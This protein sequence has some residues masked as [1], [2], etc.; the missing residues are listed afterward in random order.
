MARRG[1]RWAKRY[2]S[3]APGPS[4]YPIEFEHDPP[5]AARDGIV[6]IEGAL[7]L[8]PEALA[9]HYATHEAGHVVAAQVAGIPITSAR[10]GAGRLDASGMEVMGTVNY[11]AYDTTWVGFGA[12][13]AAGEV[14][15]HRW[16]DEHGK[17]TPNGRS[18][19]VPPV[20][21]PRRKQS[22]AINS[23]CG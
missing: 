8:P 10:L 3:E 11:G 23:A 17:A 1:R 13:F 22:L 7:D 16:L 19:W 18:R 15:S 20:T 12:T 4:K 2:R 6:S 21:A 5:A 9:H 14:A